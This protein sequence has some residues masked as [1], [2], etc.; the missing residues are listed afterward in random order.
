MHDRITVI[1]PTGDRPV[2]F[3]LCRKWIAHQTL[4]PFQWVV[5]DDGKIPLAPGPEMEYV[6]REPKPND[7]KRTLSL[8]LRTALPLV[9]GD[10]V[11]IMEDDE[12]YAPTYI[13]EM[14]MRLR[15]HKLVGITKA[16]YYH[17]FA[18]SCAQLGNDRHASLAETGFD[19]S[20]IPGVL[21]IV[22]DDDP[23]FDV[24]IWQRF[25]S[26]GHLFL[27][28]DIPLYVG[29]KGL[30]GRAG[31][32]AGHT[33]H[34]Y[35][36]NYDTPD[37][38]IL[39]AWIPNDYQHY[40]KIIGMKCDPQYKHFCCDIIVPAYSG[41]AL[42]AKCFEMIKQN[43]THGQYRVIWVD[44]GSPTRTLAEAALQDMNYI[45]IKL[46]KNLGFVRAANRGLRVSNADY[47]CLM[48]N[49]VFVS[50][51]WLDKMIAALKRDPK[52]GIVGPL[53][54]PPPANM[55]GA[56]DSPHNIRYI[57]DHFGGKVFPE[58]IGL[59]DF[60]RKLEMIYG[61]QTR[62]V[63]FVAFFCSVMKRE[64]FDKVGLLDAN[65]GIGMYD[66]ND[67]NMAARALGYKTELVNNTCVVHIGRQTF[68]MM[69]SVEGF[70]VNALVE[71]NHEYINRK[72]GRTV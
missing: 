51:G 21:E 49:D 30:P 20:L 25:Y 14:A 15:Q 39:R 33:P 36:G 22:A 27:D 62:P 56:Y 48:N 29:I 44:N 38:R 46:P 4:K 19:A 41:D 9:K 3:D 66:D 26:V 18:G 42:T 10:K 67:Y 2:A 52:L 40:F 71:K 64:V 50:S 16:K 1:T 60:N 7:P 6:R 72:W 8:N 12:Y 17:L 11:L 61:D 54:A 65:F 13:A 23:F 28:Y 53:T 24:R 69:E 57:E 35:R 32:G 55:P 34:F 5:I 31:I 70:N 37:R 47:I 43:T 59:E 58:Y 68:N 63:S 45:S